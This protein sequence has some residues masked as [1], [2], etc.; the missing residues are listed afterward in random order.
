[1]PGIEDRAIGQ[2]TEHRRQA[3][4]HGLRVTAAEVAATAGIDKEG[5]PREQ[6]V[7]HVEALAM[8]EG[9]SPD[10]TVAQALK[11]FDIPTTKE[12]FANATRM[13]NAKRPA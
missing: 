13:Q 7:L 10:I 4:I 8:I 3:S 2:R 9:V 6:V 11:E 1:M 5:I 12:M